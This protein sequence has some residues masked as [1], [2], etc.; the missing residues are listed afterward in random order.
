[1]LGKLISKADEFVFTTRKDDFSFGGDG[2]DVFFTFSGV[3]LLYG[4]AGRD[5]FLVSSKDTVY[6]NG[7][8]GYD[9][10]FLDRDLGWTVHRDGKHVT[11]QAE[12]SGNAVEMDGVEKVRLV[13]FDL[14]V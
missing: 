13:D 7:G 3:D 10:A 14:M 4:S 8:A 1:M 2:N 5:V 9:V 6:L 11:A 12:G